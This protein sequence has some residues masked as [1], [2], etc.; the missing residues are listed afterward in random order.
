MWCQSKTHIDSPITNVSKPPV[1]Y[2]IWTLIPTKWHPA[3]G[4]TGEEKQK[5]GFLWPHG[6]I[7]TFSFQHDRPQIG[8]QSDGCDSLSVALEPCSLIALVRVCEGSQ[9]CVHL[10]GFLTLHC[11]CDEWDDWR[12]SRRR[13]EGEEAWQFEWLLVIAIKPI[14][15]SAFERRVRVSNNIIKL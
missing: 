9:I 8:I 3:R 13:K 5:I 6:S 1:R 15:P 11:K 14:W 4:L 2:V 10:G 12:H 7:E